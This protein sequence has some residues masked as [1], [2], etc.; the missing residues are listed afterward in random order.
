M[1]L[2]FLSLSALHFQMLNNF[3]MIS[4]SLLFRRRTRNQ[5]IGSTHLSFSV[6]VCDFCLFC[7]PSL[8]YLLYALITFELRHFSKRNKF[9][10]CWRRN[11]CC[12][13]MLLKW[14]YSSTLLPIIISIRIRLSKFIKWMI[15]LLSC[16]IVSVF[17]LFSL[18]SHFSSAFGFFPSLL[19]SIS[20][21]FGSLLSSIH[22]ITI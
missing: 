5:Y 22:T 18:H 2:F 15:F 17:R 6:C 11:V 8:V 9:V 10:K 13:C 21:G 16:S 19:L 14:L 7:S 4:F 12:V 20:S 1:S 3:L